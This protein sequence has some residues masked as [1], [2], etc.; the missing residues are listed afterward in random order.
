MKRDLN[1]RI[2]L[3]SLAGSLG[4]SF[5]IAGQDLA[6]GKGKVNNAIVAA[7]EKCSF[8]NGSQI[9]IVSIPYSE[10][11]SNY[12]F[13]E[14]NG[15]ISLIQIDIKQG[16]IFR[17]Y[18]EVVNLIKQTKIKDSLLILFSNSFS[19]IKTEK[20]NNSDS[21]NFNYRVLRKKKKTKGYT[22]EMADEKMLT[23]QKSRIQS[24][25]F[26]SNSF[27]INRPVGD[28]EVCIIPF[29]SVTSLCSVLKGNKCFDDEP[30]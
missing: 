6:L 28:S 27:F 22:I 16:E 9:L 8:F 11:E 5:N 23:K 2:K 4:L 21:L 25:L 3:F 7:I 19:T 18:V 29:A 15:A 17:E 30:R 1:M 24:I 26:E 13:W 12:V 14:K 20:G 10:I